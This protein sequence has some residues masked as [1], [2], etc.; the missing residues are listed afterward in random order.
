MSPFSFFISLG[1]SMAMNVGL[2]LFLRW[3]TKRFQ[4]WI[5]HME[6]VLERNKEQQIEIFCLQTKLSEVQIRLALREKQKGVQLDEQTKGLIRLAV[7]NPSPSE[8]SAAAFIVCKRLK[9]RI[10]R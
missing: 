10:D 9:E 8:A 1:V 5:K 7:S 4:I 3:G 6:G 2:V